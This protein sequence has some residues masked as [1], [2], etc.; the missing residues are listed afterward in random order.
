VASTIL[1]ADDE[2]NIVALIKLYLT[3]EGYIVESAKDGQEALEKARKLAPDL[4]LVDIMMPRVDGWE[5][6]RRLRADGGTPVI[7]LTARAEDVDKI[8]GLELGA[9]DYVTKPFNP[10][11][12]VARVKAVLRRS[13]P[14]D[15]PADVLTVADL[16]IDVGRREVRVAGTLVQ[17]RNKE[18]ELLLELARNPGLVLTRDM[19]L[20][21]VWDYAYTGNTRTVDVHV[22][23]L[24]DRLQGSA[25]E[26]Q[27]VRGLGYKL[28]VPDAPDGIVYASTTTGEATEAAGSENEPALAGGDCGTADAAHSGRSG[29]VAVDFAGL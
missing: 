8:V 28:V 6:V 3:R 24:R 29:V 20:S 14:T 22:T 18:F 4:A 11:E 27:S 16:A 1:V 2:K 15:A 26:I 12:L 10:R 23:A 7:L 9:D 17:L 13:Q 5:V 19:L 25:V 21:R